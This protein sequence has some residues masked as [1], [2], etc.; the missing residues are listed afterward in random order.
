M[1]DYSFQPIYYKLTEGELRSLVG[2]GLVTCEQVQDIVAASLARTPDRHADRVVSV[3]LNRAGTI[4]VRSIHFYGGENFGQ[5]YRFLA[6]VVPVT[7]RSAF[8]RFLNARR[9]Q[10]LTRRLAFTY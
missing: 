5:P 3:P 1:R 8:S 4:E 7:T 6:E 10:W 2:D 9:L